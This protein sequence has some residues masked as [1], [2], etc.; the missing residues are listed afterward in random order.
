V[1]LAVGCGTTQP[2]PALTADSSGAV[3][4]EAE[5]DRPVR[6]IDIPTPEYPPELQGIGA[7]GR[8][9]LEYIVGPDGRV[10]PRSIKVV[11]VG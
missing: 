4:Q 11:G 3:Y 1:L 2:S 7:E 6:P 8:V 9:R 10:E 5:L